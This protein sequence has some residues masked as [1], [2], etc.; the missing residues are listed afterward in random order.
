[1]GS[2][3]TELMGTSRMRI[4]C[5]PCASAFA[6][7]Y[8]V[9]SDGPFTIFPA[10]HLARTIHRVRTDGQVDDTLVSFQF[11]FQQGCV[12]LLDKTRFEECLK[13]LVH[14]LRLGREQQAGGSHVQSVHDKRTGGLGIKIVQALENRVEAVLARHGEHACRFVYHH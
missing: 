7:Q 2:M 12:T 10:Y 5:D 4:E 9:G 14:L 3:Y 13:L 8:L 11:S 6:F 1:M